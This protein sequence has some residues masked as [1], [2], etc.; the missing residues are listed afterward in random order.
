MKM[1]DFIY[2]ND[3]HQ[4]LKNKW[5]KPSNVSEAKCETLNMKAALTIRCFL[6]RIPCYILLLMKHSLIRFGRN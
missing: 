1:N 2:L 4:P 6:W 5:V 3:L